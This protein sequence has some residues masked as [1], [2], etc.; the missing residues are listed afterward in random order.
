MDRFSFKVLSK[1]IEKGQTG[2]TKLH[3]SFLFHLNDLYDED[4]FISVYPK[5]FSNDKLD[6]LIVL[7]KD[8][9]IKIL[10]GDE[11]QVIYTHNY[12]KVVKK[13]LITRRNRNERQIL[14][15]TYDNG[16]TLEFNSEADSNYDLDEVYSI[17]I[18]ELYKIM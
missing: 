9:Y 13:D 7:L 10:K 8:G 5:N 3:K 17:A 2:N 15:L 11:N 6:E 4:Q 16:E 1:F 14:T 12:S 18:R